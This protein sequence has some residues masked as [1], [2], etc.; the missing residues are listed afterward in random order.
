MG[1]ETTMLSLLVK[2]LKL[3]YYCMV[4]HLTPLSQGHN[5]AKKKKKKT[6]MPLKLNSYALPQLTSKWPSTSWFPSSHQISRLVDN[7]IYSQLSSNNEIIMPFQ[8]QKGKQRPNVLCSIFE[9]Y[10]QERK[11]NLWKFINWY[12]CR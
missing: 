1:E 6:L 4:I 5:I 11:L 8:K 3:N 12:Q 7:C 9:T 10:N 2:M